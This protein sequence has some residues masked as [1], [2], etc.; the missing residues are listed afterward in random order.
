MVTSGMRLPMDVPPEKR[1]SSQRELIVMVSPKAGLRVSPTE[2]RAVDSP[3]L[4]SFAEILKSSNA[5]M[6]PLFAGAR[7]RIVMQ[8]RALPSLREPRAPDL[9]VFFKIGTSNERMEEIARNL[10]RLEQVRAAYIKPPS[11]PPALN[12]M[13]PKA[14]APPHKD[15]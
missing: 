12:A 15:P 7:E 9:S 2:M 11:E 13:L 8:S 5:T 1:L 6:R 4:S 3:F 10:R 14:A